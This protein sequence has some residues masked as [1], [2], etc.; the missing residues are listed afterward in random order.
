MPTKR[1]QSFGPAETALTKT[2][3]QGIKPF[4]PA[5]LLIASPA[6]WAADYTWQGGN[7]NWTASHWDQPGFPDDGTGNVFIDGGN[8]THS[9]VN[10]DASAAVGTVNIDDGDALNLLDGS[11]LTLTGGT[12]TN[13]GTI[14]VHGAGSIYNSGTISGGG[15]V[16]GDGPGVYNPSGPVASWLAGGG[17]YQNL[18]LQGVNVGSGPAYGG[19]GGLGRPTL[20][21]V[22]FQGDNAVV[23]FADVSNSTNNG[24]LAVNDLSAMIVID[25]GATIA[26]NGTIAVHGTGLIYNAGTIS[27]GTIQGDGPGAYNPSGPVAS[28]LTGGGTYQN[29]TLQGVNVGSGPAYGGGAAPTLSGVAFQ[30]DNAVVGGAH[31]SNS[32]NSGNL[33][34]ND[35]S[36]VYTSGTISNSGTIALNGAGNQ[37]ALLLNADTVFAGGGNTV[38]GNGSN[39]IDTNSGAARTLT[40]GSGYTVEGGGSLGGLNPGNALSIINQ[41]TILA[42]HGTLQIS[43]NVDSSGVLAVAADGVMQQN[44][45]TVAAQT[46]NVAAEGAY[47]LASGQLEA[48]A[49][50]GNFTQTGGTF[51]AGVGL[52]AGNLSG[53]YKMN[54]G[55]LEIDLAGHTAGS[56]DHLNLGGNLTLAGGSLALVPQ[57]GFTLSAGE[58]LDLVD[59]QGTRN[60]T[61][62]GLAEGAAIPVGGGNAYLTYAAGN[63]REIA[64][65]SPITTGSVNYVS[66]TA[67]DV[68]YVAGT[69]SAP[70][71]SAPITTR[72]KGVD[73]LSGSSFTL[74]SHETLNLDGGNGTLNVGQGGVFAGNGTVNGSLNNAGLLEVP[75]QS[76][77]P[78]PALHAQ[79]PSPDAGSQASVMNV[80]GPVDVT[81]ALRLYVEGNAGT[82]Y[83]Q[84]HGDQT[85]TLSGT[86]Q[87]VLKPELFAQ[88][89]YTPHAG[90][91]FDFVTGLGGILL[92]SSL[93]YEFLVDQAGADL[94]S[95]LHLT[96]FS[97]GIA[98]DTDI[99]YLISEDLFSF[100]LA[101]GGTVLRGVA[102]A[103]LAGPSSQVPLPSTLWLLVAGGLGLAGANR[104]KQ[105]H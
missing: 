16:Q 55:A 69:R 2:I 103:A 32:A 8:P 105:I 21:G 53:D 81:G 7:G 54:G 41:G 31:L 96:P 4:L 87:I 97:S 100:Y 18:T 61:F 78:N 93:A 65:V 98:G 15:T 104:K 77:A 27:G 68:A 86:L 10:L 101:D 25:P 5:L 83:S 36:T 39:Y 35:G 43:A 79:A 63:G 6:A 71:D 40:I 9:S 89:G 34:L 56:Y 12:S 20:S 51:A 72:Y 58:V 44:G 28:W 60:G 45:G 102:L 99:L 92:D 75:T 64:L 50:N 62:A 95:W 74:G 49:F 85:V 82:A 94:L 59:V 91:T 24:N 84:L 33:T 1:A 46:V 13:N 23:G 57:A 29:L 38:L 88:S 19:G 76:Q 42:E 26:N 30:G 66:A 47:A 3:R 70:T 17:T 14:S 48:N 80:S 67:S 90:D 52:A 37:T 22:T 73:V 11:A